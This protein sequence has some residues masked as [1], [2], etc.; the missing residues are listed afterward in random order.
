MQWDG[1]DEAGAGA[2]AGLYLVRANSSE[3][4]ACAKILRLE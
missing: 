4:V 2:S 1:R 3:Q